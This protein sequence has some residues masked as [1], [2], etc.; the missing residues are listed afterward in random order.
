MPGPIPNR[1]DQNARPRAR[2][3]GDNAKVTRGIAR[4][5]DWSGFLPDPAWHPT[6]RQ[7]WDSARTSGQEDY[8]QNSDIAMLF[9]I[10]QET[11][12]YCKS[13]KKSAMMFQAITSAMT[14]LLLTEGDRRKVRIELGEKPAE[15]PNLVSIGKEQYKDAASG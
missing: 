7:I 11:S 12:E 5:V 8:Y 4:E 13:G 9:F 2:R 10:C 1:D 14:S 15:R 3:G 6:A